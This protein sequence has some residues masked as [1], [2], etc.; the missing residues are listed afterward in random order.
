MIVWEWLYSAI[1]VF[2]S[3]PIYICI[4]SCHFNKDISIKNIYIRSRLHTHRDVNEHSSLWYSYT[5]DH[6]GILI[7]NTMNQ[8]N[9]TDIH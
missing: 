5:N 3:I 1:T 2:H 4:M 8:H 7:S 9:T 6:R